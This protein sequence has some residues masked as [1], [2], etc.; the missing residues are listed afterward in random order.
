MRLTRCA[1]WVAMLVCSALTTPAA[2]NSWTSTVTGAWHDLSWSL[3]VRPDISQDAIMVT[4][5]GQKAIIIDSTTVSNFPSTLTISNLNL[6]GTSLSTNTLLLNYTGTTYPL[7]VYDN[8]TV[9]ANAVLDNLFGAISLEGASPTLMV[10]GGTVN[11]QGGSNYFGGNCYIGY[12]TNF[13]QYNLT[14][15]W[16]SMSNLLMDSGGAFN[17]IDGATTISG[18]VSLLQAYYYVG[19]GAHCAIIHGT[20]ATDSINVS[21]GGAFSQGYATVTVTNVLNIGQ[22]F[23]RFT[24][25]DGYY[26]LTNGT[27]A[28]AQTHIG[29]LAN[30]YFYQF[31]G[32]HRTGFLDIIG[33]DRY[34][35]GTYELDGGFLQCTNDESIQVYSR[36][37]QNGGTNN[38]G[39]HLTL[40][41]G[42]YN[43]NGG[44]LGAS[45]VLVQGDG[46]Y[47]SEFQPI[48]VQ[49]NGNHFVTN[50]LTVDS[51]GTYRLYGGTFAAGTIV[52]HTYGP[53]GFFDHSGGTLSSGA[54][55]FSGGTL[56][57]SGTETLGTLTLRG[58]K[59]IDSLSTNSVQYFSAS[60]HIPW[61]SNA[62]LEID[63]WQS[64]TNHI[65]FGNSANALTSRQLQ[66]IIFGN[67]GGY[68]RLLDTGELASWPV[69]E[70]VFEQTGSSLTL[71][72]PGTAIL[73]WADN[74]AGP[75]TDVPGAVSPFTPSL[76]APYK[77]FRLRHS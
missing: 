70:L 30:G 50:A 56:S 43:L 48:F 28:T 38:V 27:L 54:I 69:P 37:N 46:S 52:L 49:S 60:A 11:Q 2:V 67:G 47:G 29:Q 13:G 77:F 59:S 74:P 39:N 3:G 62:V 33:D 1:L 64:G 35:Y 12:T 34:G 18:Y 58:S 6:A 21:G 15:G 31:G 24:A 4:N 42:F 25:N 57:A 16:L 32:T 68:G 7:H 75:Y 45:N 22:L 8:I 36:L 17:Q 76:T 19:N 10:S 61:E 41:D 63:G 65:Y 66:Q 53:P 26:Y 20:F 73:Q 9:D 72:W 23:S 5:Y 51:F 44:Q 55:I 40:Y 14:N 71:S